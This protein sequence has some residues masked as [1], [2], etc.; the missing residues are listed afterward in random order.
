MMTAMSAALMIC[1]TTLMAVDTWVIPPASG[2]IGSQQAMRDPTPFVTLFAG[3]CIGLLMGLLV[4][5]VAT[6][7]YGCDLMRS[8]GYP[9]WLTIAYLLFPWLIEL[10]LALDGATVY[11]GPTGIWQMADEDWRRMPSMMPIPPIVMN[12]DGS[13]YVQGYGMP[14]QQPLPRQPIE[15]VQLGDDGGDGPMTI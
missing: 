8:F 14:P 6:L 2:G 9:S 3:L 13:C 7:V 12:P 11:L 10:I 15:Y 1:M 5:T 4:L